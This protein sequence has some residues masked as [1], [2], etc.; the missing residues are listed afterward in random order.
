MNF[1]NVVQGILKLK[2][3]ERD[4]RVGNKHHIADL[5]EPITN[6]DPQNQSQSMFLN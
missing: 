3:C 4:G 5:A 1:R 2:S 6:S